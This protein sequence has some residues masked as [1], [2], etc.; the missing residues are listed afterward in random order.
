MSKICKIA[1]IISN[2][3]VLFFDFD[4]TI[5]FTDDANFI[6]YK[7]AIKTVI[8]VN[9]NNYSLCHDR[10]D[11]KILKE[12]F[13]DIKATN[14]IKIIALKEEIYND[15]LP[16]VSPN[17]Y[18]VDL[19]NNYRNT[20]PII[21]VTN[22]R[23]KRL[24]DSLKYLNLLDRFDYLF[25]QEKFEKFSSNK[26]SAAISYL[27]IEPENIVVFENENVEMCNAK[28]AWIKSEKIYIV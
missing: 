27:K 3:D 2:K 11:R 14:L 22:C 17:K 21:L 9:I 6:A 7:H 1:P 28:N 16:L 13:P 4:G 10:I 26:Y 12:I 24:Y 8:G 15:F 23:K 20:N 5:A 18:L 25:Y 19:L